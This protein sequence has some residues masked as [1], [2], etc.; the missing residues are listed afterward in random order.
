MDA[1]PFRDLAG[2]GRGT[3]LAPLPNWLLFADRNERVAEHSRLL[4]QLGGDLCL[5]YLPKSD[6]LDDE[7]PAIQFKRLPGQRLEKLLR[8]RFKNDA[9]RSHGASEPVLIPLARQWKDLLAREASCFRVSAPQKQQNM[10]HEFVEM[11]TPYQTDFDRVLDTF[12]WFLANEVKT[13]CQTS[14]H[15]PNVT[16]DPIAGGQLTLDS[17]LANEITQALAALSKTKE[18]EWMDHSS[19]GMTPEM[20][21]ATATAVLGLMHLDQMP[22]GVPWLT[23]ASTP[24]VLGRL[25]PGTPSNWRRVIMEMAITTLP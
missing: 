5:T 12:D 20:F 16:L 10:E 23:G 13:F 7:L 25:T 11:A 3:P 1:L 17:R 9:P 2:Q 22:A 21:T 24:R 18:V 4:V 8:E 19:I 15:S 14:C 6:G